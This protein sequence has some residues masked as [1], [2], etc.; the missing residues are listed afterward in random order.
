MAVV[1][2]SSGRRVKDLNS[3]PLVPGSA[4]V[5]PRIRGFIADGA[6]S[7]DMAHVVTSLQMG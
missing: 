2:C 1:V 5:D 7:H 3:D 4:I 6:A